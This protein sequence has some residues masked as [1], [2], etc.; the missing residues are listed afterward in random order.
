M[1]NIHI[2]KR[3]NHKYVT[4]VV[5]QMPI[6]VFQGNVKYHNLCLLHVKSP[7]WLNQR[8]RQG[9]LLAQRKINL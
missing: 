4:T 6:N 7:S 1:V 3:K 5:N 9:Q 2:C 8:S